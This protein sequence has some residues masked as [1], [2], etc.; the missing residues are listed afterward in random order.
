ME[1]TKTNIIGGLN[2]GIDRDIG[3]DIDN[4]N[5]IISSSSS[6][7]SYASDEEVS[8]YTGEAIETTNYM[9]DY[10]MIEKDEEFEVDE[11]IICIELMNNNRIYLN[12]QQDWTFKDVCIFIIYY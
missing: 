9:D 12:Y 4:T 6:D 8:E 11:K 7:C 3:I 10:V 2:I 1:E 5:E